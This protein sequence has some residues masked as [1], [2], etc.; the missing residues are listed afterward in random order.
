MTS[1]PTATT[2]NAKAIVVEFENGN[3]M[4]TIDEVESTPYIAVQS[5]EVTI[6]ETRAEPEGGE[7][8]CFFFT[9]PMENYPQAFPAPMDQWETITTTDMEAFNWYYE[10]WNSESSSGGKIVAVLEQRQCR[11]CG[12][13]P[14]FNQKERRY[15]C[16]VCDRP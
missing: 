1:A 9:D 11:Q 8:K 12:Q 2:I 7:Y 14:F 15:F 10:P 16:P 13:E 4:Y 5:K 6:G 3:A